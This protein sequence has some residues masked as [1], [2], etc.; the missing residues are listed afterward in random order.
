[1]EVH[2]DQKGMETIT[3]SSNYDR[4]DL[5]NSA[6]MLYGE[7]QLFTDTLTRPYTLMHYFRSILVCL[8]PKEQVPSDESICKFIHLGKSYIKDPAKTKQ[9]FVDFLVKHKEFQTLRYL[10]PNTTTSGTYQGIISTFKKHANS[11]YTM[12]HSHQP[13]STLLA[14]NNHSMIH[15]Q[16]M[17]ITEVTD[18]EFYKNPFDWTDPKCKQSVM[19]TSFDQVCLQKETPTLQAS[20]SKI[21]G[22]SNTVPNLKRSPTTSPKVTPPHSPSTQDRK[23]QPNQ[24]NNQNQTLLEQWQRKEAKYPFSS[25]K[26]CAVFDMQCEIQLGNYSKEGVL[27]PKFQTTIKNLRFH[28]FVKQNSAE[29]IIKAFQE[30]FDKN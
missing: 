24:D 22:R 2:F 26:V 19:E 6:V 10:S 27:Q 20:F 16:R 7:S 13:F 9:P 18:N 23:K 5:S 30:E 21:L 3:G 14:L 11:E 12:I 29:L 25:T 1:M 17:E 8:Y 15:S 28:P 4:I